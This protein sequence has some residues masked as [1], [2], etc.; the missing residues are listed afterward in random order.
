MPALLNLHAGT[1][2][3]PAPD[4][5]YGFEDGGRITAEWLHNGR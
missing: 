3:L 4:T 5:G 1:D 2:Q